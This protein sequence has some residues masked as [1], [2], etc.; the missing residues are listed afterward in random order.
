[1]LQNRSTKEKPKKKQAK[2]N[3]TKPT[4]QNSYKSGWNYQL[5]PVDFSI[6]ISEWKE[7]AQDGQ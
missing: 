7:Q 6:P 1:M 3:K 4:P 5:F 2:Q